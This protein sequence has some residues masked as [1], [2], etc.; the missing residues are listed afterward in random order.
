VN[1]AL[2]EHVINAEYETLNCQNSRIVTLQQYWMK[3]VGP[4]R[5]DVKDFWPPRTCCSR[6]ARLRWWRR[7]QLPAVGQS[8]REVSRTWRCRSHSPS[9]G[10]TDTFTTAV[11]YQLQTRLTLLFYFYWPA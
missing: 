1:G 2:M 8:H 5:P 6:V 9:L 4:V 7:Y 11:S 10:T 3:K